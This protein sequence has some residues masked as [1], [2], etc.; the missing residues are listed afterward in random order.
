MNTERN[1]KIGA[2]VALL[3]IAALVIYFTQTK[4][5]NAP[6]TN[7]PPTNQQPETPT[8]APTSYKDLIKVFT[9][10]PNQTV[11][12]P[13]S[14]TGEA[15]GQWYF[16]ATF[17]ILLVD[18]NNK[19]LGTGYAQAIGDWMT[20]NYVPFSATLP[21]SP[22]TTPTGT[23]ILQRSNASGLPENDDEY[24][25]PV[26]FNSQAQQRDVQLFYY[27]PNND[28]D[29]NGNVQ[30]SKAGLVA[31]QRKIPVTTTP[32]QDTIKLLIQGDLS[33]TEKSSGI[34]TE[35][36]L[37]GLSLTGAALQNKILTLSFEDPQNKTTG[38]ACRVEILKQQIEATA[39]QFPDINAV[40]FQPN[41]IFQP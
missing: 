1:V 16:E 24:R 30:C 31:V 34:T 28:K 26:R 40:K 37:P 32:L 25:I 11:T 14:I 5:T 20:T 21:F 41:T 38:G 33:N 6:N 13:L 35:F 22:P 39:K 18:A 10:T 17:P 36:P 8:E 12:T 19:T 3:L 9:P 27:N 4:K 2:L 29:G 23:L 7:N 15:R